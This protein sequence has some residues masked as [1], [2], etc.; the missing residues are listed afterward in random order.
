MSCHKINTGFGPGEWDWCDMR[1]GYTYVKTAEFVDTSESAIN[2]EADS[3]EMVVKD[4][5]GNTVATLETPATGLA[6]VAPNKLNISVG[7]PITDTAGVYTGTLVWTR[8]ATG[9]VVP[10]IDFTFTIE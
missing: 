6:I 4:A 5:D 7:S 3:F 1:T 9:A 10:I 8:D 2:I